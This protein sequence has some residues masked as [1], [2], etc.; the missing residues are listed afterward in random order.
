MVRPVLA[1]LAVTDALDAHVSWTLDDASVVAAAPSDTRIDPRMVDAMDALDGPAFFTSDHV[2]ALGIAALMAA[3]LIGSALLTWSTMRAVRDDVE[4][5]D[6]E[7]QS[8]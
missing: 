4:Y 3:F 5:R 8:V 2:R 7:S 6:R 1:W